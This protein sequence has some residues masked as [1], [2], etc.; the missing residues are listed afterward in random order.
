MMCAT[1]LSLLV[2]LEVGGWRLVAEVV[3][4]DGGLLECVSLYGFIV[5]FLFKI[6]RV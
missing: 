1:K 5:K 2:G 3:A 6:S 4:E